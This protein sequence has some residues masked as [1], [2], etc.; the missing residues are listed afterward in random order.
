MKQAQFHAAIVKD[1]NTHP[2]PPPHEE[3]L[4]Y[5]EPPRRVLKRAR[6]AIEECK[7]TFN[8]R[9][10]KP[11]SSHRMHNSG[12]CGVHPVPKKVARVRK[13]EHV[14]AR[15]EDE[16]MLLL[17]RQAGPSQTQAQRATQSRS[18]VQT[19]TASPSRTQQKKTTG[20]DSDS[21][22]EIE[23]ES[24]DEGLLLDSAA[25]PPERAAPLPTPARSLSPDPRIDRNR[26]K[27]RIIGYTYPLAD[28][29]KNTERGDVVTKAVE[30]LA[31]IVK[32]V[33][34]RPFASKR[35]DEML[36]CMHELRKVSLEVCMS[37]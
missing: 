9:E 30:D 14:R 16:E 15:D 35:F 6:E 8:V 11:P 33:V 32:E 36:E 31:Y 18:F 13:D 5:F 2:L 20:N 34:V 37:L 1:L 28:F 23:D 29:R 25:R 10:G 26:P 21:A 22:T 7:S 3:L 17:D 27:G 24:D 12:S 19:Q 4:K